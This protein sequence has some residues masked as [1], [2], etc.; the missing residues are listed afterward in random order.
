[1]YDIVK[2]VYLIIICSILLIL[3]P[4]PCRSEEWQRVPK[5]ERNNLGLKAEDDGEFWLVHVHFEYI[6]NRTDIT[7]LECQLYSANL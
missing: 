7:S 3:H 2:C 4:R 6:N 5:K 1:M